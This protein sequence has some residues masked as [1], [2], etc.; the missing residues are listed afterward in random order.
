[1]TMDSLI[2]ISY[3]LFIN[4]NNYNNNIFFADILELNFLRC[5]HIHVT[6]MPVRKR[7]KLICLAAKF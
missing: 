1:M 3:V 7:Q 6:V 5:Q 2:I 4:N